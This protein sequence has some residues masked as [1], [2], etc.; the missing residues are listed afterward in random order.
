M[1]Y[2]KTFRHEIIFLV[3]ALDLVILFIFD[4]EVIVKFGSMRWK[5]FHDNWNCFDFTIALASKYPYVFTNS[6]FINVAGLRLFRLFKLA[7]SFPSLR[8]LVE[9]L[10]E[11]FGSVI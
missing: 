4:F 1:G 7:K 10:M 2:Q 9:S 11:S 5:Y 6:A 8:G 3:T